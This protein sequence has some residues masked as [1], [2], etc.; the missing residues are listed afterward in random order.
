MVTPGVRAQAVVRVVRQGEPYLEILSVAR[1]LGMDLIIL[2]TH[3]RTGLARVLMGSTTEKVVRHAD[4]PV[5]VV[6][7]HEHEFLAEKSRATE[8]AR[9]QSP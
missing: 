3:G 5:L 2:S 1:E 9:E 8:A 4:C 6:R 7:E